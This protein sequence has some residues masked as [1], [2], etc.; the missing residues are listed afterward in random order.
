MSQPYKSFCVF[1]T[2]LPRFRVG[3]EET[4]VGREAIEMHSMNECVLFQGFYVIRIFALHLPVQDLDHAYPGP[5]SVCDPVL[6][7]Y[8]CWIEVAVGIGGDYGADYGC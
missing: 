4:L 5:G 6:D 3:I 7:G 1:N 8:E 2:F